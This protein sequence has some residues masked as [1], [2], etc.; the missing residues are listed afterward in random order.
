MP[1]MVEY[2][3]ELII[4]LFVKTICAE[5]RSLVLVNFDKKFFSCV[6]KTEGRI[7]EI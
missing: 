1:K 6:Y 5:S 3:K 7:D 4:L 2:F